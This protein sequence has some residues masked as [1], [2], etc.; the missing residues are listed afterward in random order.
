[1]RRR[2]LRWVLL[3]AL[4]GAAALS[5]CYYDPYIGSYFPYPP[6]PPI[7]YGPP[8]YTYGAPPLQAPP[9]QGTAPVQQTPLPPVQ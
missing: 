4:A 8:P 2:R 7:P 5:G 1:M 3:A 6:P 9:R